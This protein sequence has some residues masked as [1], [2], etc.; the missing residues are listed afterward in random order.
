MRMASSSVRELILP[1]VDVRD[2]ER[3]GLDGMLNDCESP[4]CLVPFNLE[5][6]SK[7]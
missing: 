4:A 1:L 3:A 6:D 5:H 2:H 7:C